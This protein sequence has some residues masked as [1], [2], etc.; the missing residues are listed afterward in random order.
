MPRKTKKKSNMPES[1]EPNPVSLDK[2]IYFIPEDVPSGQ[3]I[4]CAA[5]NICYNFDDV[6]NCLENGTIDKIVF[7]PLTSHTTRH[8]IYHWAKIFN[9]KIQELYTTHFPSKPSST[10]QV[11]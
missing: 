3:R 2:T 5:K 10:N 8:Y 4:F 1:V 6:I 7:H 9:P 11:A